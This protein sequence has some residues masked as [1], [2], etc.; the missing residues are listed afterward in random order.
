MKPKRAGAQRVAGDDVDRGKRL[1][2]L[3]RSTHLSSCTVLH[4]I[5]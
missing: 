1:V 5:D 3:R 2:A 4:G